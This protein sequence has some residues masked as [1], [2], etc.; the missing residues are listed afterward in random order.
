[1][2]KSLFSNIFRFALF[3]VAAAVMVTACKNDDDDN[4]GGGDIV[5]DGVYIY[6][7]SVPSSAVENSASMAAGVVD[8]FPN[9]AAP[10]EGMFE[11]YVYITADGNFQFK[12]IS[13]STTTVWGLSGALTEGDTLS[14]G[15]IVADGE[16]IS[17]SNDGLYHVVVDKTSEQVVLYRVH[18]WGLVGD[19][20]PSSDDLTLVEQSLTATSGSWQVTGVEMRANWFKVRANQEW[21]F[22]ITDG[23]RGFTDLAAP[24]NEMVIGGSNL[25]IDAS[26]IG[27]YTI[28][29]NYSYGE[30]FSM[31][32]EMTGTIDFVDWT[33]VALEL[34]G[35]GVSADNANAVEDPS[36]WTWGNVLQDD[37][38]APTVNGDVYTWTWT[39]ATLVADAGFKIRTINAE[40]PANGNGAAFNVGHEAIDAGNSSSNIIEN[41]GNFQASVGGNYDITVVIDAASGDAKTVTIV[42]S[43]TK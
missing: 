9:P 18:S 20:T 16:P 35:D 29:F 14:T 6:G 7:T 17:V 37:A 1:M 11:K 36:G 13:G 38:G 30:G 5:L 10:R 32:K 27:I 3:F 2:K 25:M 34:V 40:A 23:V 43:T 28:T 42:E 31:T 26:E 33:G 15:T 19:A 8:D 4:G 41:G 39:N 12:E 22:E 21:G 24:E